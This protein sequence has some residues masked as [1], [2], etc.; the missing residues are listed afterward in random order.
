VTLPLCFNTFGM[1]CF[2]T[3][4]PCLALLVSL[5]HT[6]H[7]LGSHSACALIHMEIKK[8]V[9]WGNYIRCYPANRLHHFTEYYSTSMKKPGFCSLYI[10]VH[11]QLNHSTSFTNIELDIIKY[12]HS[13]MKATYTSRCS[14]HLL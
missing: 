3:C 9:A 4:L 6:A 7:H 10:C 8:L 11:N 14:K 1:V 5:I 13:K 2:E 12:I